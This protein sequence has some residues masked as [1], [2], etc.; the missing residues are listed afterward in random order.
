MA[1]EPAPTVVEILGRP[2]KIKCA[3]APDRL[4]AVTQMVNEQLRE[5]QR[6]FPAS[7]LADVAILAALNLACEILENKEDY[8]RLRRDI[9]ERSKQLIRKLEVH[10]AYSPPGP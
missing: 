4:D 10:E 5:V 7:P 9:E 3:M 1:R 2:L 6:A 8:Q